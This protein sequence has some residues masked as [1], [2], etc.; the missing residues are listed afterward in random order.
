MQTAFC[1]ALSQVM[2]PRLEGGR[3]PARRTGPL[4]KTGTIPPQVRRSENAFATIIVQSH[5]TLILSN[6]SPPELSQRLSMITVPLTTRG[7]TCGRIPQCSGRWL[8]WSREFCRESRACDEQRGRRRHRRSPI[9][10]LADP[11]PTVYLDGGAIESRHKRQFGPRPRVPAALR[12]RKNAA[13]P[14]GVRRVYCTNFLRVSQRHSAP[15]L[16][17]LLNRKKVQACYI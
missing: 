1:L 16:A 9:D 8:W 13:D 7:C 12:C 15:A 14:N 3:G 4:T 17:G 6:F 10:G 11:A 2:R 5:G